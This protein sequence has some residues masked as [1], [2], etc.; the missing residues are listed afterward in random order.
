MKVDVLMSFSATILTQTALIARNEFD[1]DNRIADIKRPALSRSAIS[2]TEFL[3]N[4]FNVVESGIPTVA[5]Q[6]KSYVIVLAG[7]LD[8]SDMP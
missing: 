7:S 1:E 2:Y 3:T 8:T 5:N 6:K 4:P